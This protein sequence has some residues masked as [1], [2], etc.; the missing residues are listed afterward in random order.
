[1]DNFRYLTRNDPI[2]IEEPFS[3]QIDNLILMSAASQP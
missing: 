2:V 1:M 3:C